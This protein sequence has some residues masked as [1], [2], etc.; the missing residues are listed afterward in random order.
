MSNNAIQGMSEMSSSSNSGNGM[1]GKSGMGD[2]SGRK[3]TPGSIKK[4]YGKMEGMSTH[5]CEP[6]YNVMSSFMGIK[7]DKVIPISDKEDQVQLK[8]LG[9]VSSTIDKDLV[10]VGGGG[11]LPGSSVVVSRW[12]N[13][14][15]VPLILEDRGSIYFSPLIPI[16]FSIN[17]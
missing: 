9:N 10:I 13:T 11:D 3:S 16:H 15:T 14:T 1:Q 17:S 2:M 5:Y 12:K 7:V 6:S 4:M 8:H